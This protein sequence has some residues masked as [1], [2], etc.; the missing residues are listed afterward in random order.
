MVKTN[1]TG[2]RIPE[3][4]PPSGSPI[5]LDDKKLANWAKELPVANIGETARKLFQTLRSFNK[6]RIRSA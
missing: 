5:F 1:P 4:K 3:Q 2:L 6:T